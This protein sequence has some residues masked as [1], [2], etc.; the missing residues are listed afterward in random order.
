MQGTKENL[1]NLL[2]KLWKWILRM[3]LW[4]T[5]LHFYVCWMTSPN[6]YL[7]TR[8]FVWMNYLLFLSR[9]KVSTFTKLRCAWIFPLIHR[10][11]G[12]IIKSYFISERMLQK[13]AQHHPFVLKRRAG[14]M[15][16]LQLFTMIVDYWNEFCSKIS[17]E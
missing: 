16:N 17:H 7:L 14:R 13:I 2:V 8:S 11:C 1:L 9:K 4:K 10:M 12:R 3:F 15:Q 5:H 6:L